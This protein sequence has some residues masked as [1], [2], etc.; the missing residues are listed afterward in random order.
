MRYPEVKSCLALRSLHTKN[1]MKIPRVNM[2]TT[3]T[4]AAPIDAVAPAKAV[5]GGLGSSV[6]VGAKVGSDG[7]VGVMVGSAVVGASLGVI[8]GD[9]VLTTGA[10]VGEE[11]G[12]R[13]GSAVSMHFFPL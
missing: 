5:L 1:Y 13:V 3:E 6:E 4:M 9:S 2:V 10:A 7:T 11:V 12:K 8:V